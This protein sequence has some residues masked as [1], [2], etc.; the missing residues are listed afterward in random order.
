M[1]CLFDLIKLFLNLNNDSDFCFRYRIYLN[2]QTYEIENSKT[3]NSFYIHIDEKKMHHHIVLYKHTMSNVIESNSYILKKFIKMIENN[4][5][6]KQD[7][8]YSLEK[9]LF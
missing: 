2:S 9:Q 7:L 3:I 4:S 5:N 6:F 1:N 8:I